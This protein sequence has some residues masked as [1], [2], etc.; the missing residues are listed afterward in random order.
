MTEAELI[1][2][3]VARWYQRTGW[4][5]CDRVKWGLDLRYE[6][7]AIAISKTGLC[8]EL[9]A[10]ST[11][12]DLRNDLKKHKW[13]MIERGHWQHFADRFWYIVPPDLQDA[14][15]RQA[16]PRGFGVVVVREPPRRGILF[17]GANRVLEATRLHQD[18][19]ER[20]SKM[21]A[22]RSELWRLAALRYWDLGGKRAREER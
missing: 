21:M 22:R 6:A 12:A 15:V 16:A 2:A 8:D 18:T 4:A 1:H 10:K 20:R 13:K 5:V 14:A 9:E 19:T 3:A 7:D 11:K 17:C